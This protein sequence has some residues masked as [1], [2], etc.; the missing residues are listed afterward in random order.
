MRIARSQPSKRRTGRTT[1]RVVGASG[2]CALMGGVQ[3]NLRP[4]GRRIEANRVGEARMTARRPTTQ[5]P[6]VMNKRKEA[7]VWKPLEYGAPEEIR[8]PDPLVRRRNL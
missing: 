8:T 6:G 5:P 3:G 1:N 7:S 4:T 2:R